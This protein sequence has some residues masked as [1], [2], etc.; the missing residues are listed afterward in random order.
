MW[1]DKFHQ[2][3]DDFHGSVELHSNMSSYNVHLYFHHQIEYGTLY[4][5]SIQI[6]TN[7]EYTVTRKI[8]VG[9]LS[10]KSL[11]LPLAKLIRAN[12]LFCRS[13]KTGYTLF[14]DLATQYHTFPPSK[15]RL[16]RCLRK[17]WSLINASTFLTVRINFAGKQ[18]GGTITLPMNGT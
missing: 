1:F 14:Y 10:L 3:F 9:V 17:H 8:F 4:F 2:W 6:W 18:P 12:S 16:P 11:R 5:H 7:L 13:A 15:T